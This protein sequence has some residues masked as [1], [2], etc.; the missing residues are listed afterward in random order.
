MK[1]IIEENLGITVEYFI[2]YL[3]FV[4]QIAQLQDVSKINKALN[5][6][7]PDLLILDGKNI[8]PII[9]A[10]KDKYNAKIISYGQN[11]IADLCI[12]KNMTIANSNIV[13]DTKKPTLETISFR[14][15]VKKTDISIFLNSP[16]E[17]SLAQFLCL[18]YNVKVYGNVN[19]K[20]PKYLGM[21]SLMDK[22]EIINKSKIVIDLGTYDFYNAILL[23]TYPL[24]YTNDKNDNLYTS[25]HDLTSLMISLEYVLDKSNKSKLKENL[26]VLKKQC[27][28]NND[29]AFVIDCLQKLKYNDEVIQLNQILEDMTC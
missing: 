8:N 22:Y 4:S 2:R 3:P 12:V 6:F 29:L 23:D 19:I 9:K 20:N 15:N 21:V 18:N 24:I 10:Y 7:K 27:Y 28:K 26:E 5:D 1:V 25:F 14:E 11:D 16:D 17:I 13:Y